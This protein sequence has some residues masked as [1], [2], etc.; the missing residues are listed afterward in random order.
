M[1]DKSGGHFR[2]NRRKKTWKR[3]MDGLSKGKNEDGWMKSTKS[4]ISEE[5]SGTM[6]SER[7]WE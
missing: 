6:R 7:Q 1:I 3:K 4:R 5:I 2:L